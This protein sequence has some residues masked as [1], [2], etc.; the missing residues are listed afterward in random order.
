MNIQEIAP[1]AVGKKDEIEK[2]KDF[3]PRAADPFS[4]ADLPPAL[5]EFHSPTTALVNMP[6]TPAAQYIS[7]LIGALTA[8]SIV[9][10]AVFPLN[11]VVSTTGK[12]IS[13]QQPLV[14]QPFETSIIHSID[15]HEGD[16]VHKGQVLVRLD[17][18]VNDADIEDLRSQTQS[19]GAE[20]AR[21][22]AEAQG[23]DYK[24]DRDNPASTQ[25]AE[26]FLRR[27]AEF[28]AKIANYQ[29]QIASQTADLQGDL[30]N[31]DMY[32]A[33]VKVAN[34][35]RAMRARLQADQVGSRLSTLSAQNDLMEVTRSEI[36]AQHDG[37]SVRS[38][39][40]ALVAERQ[41]YIETWKA[42]IYHDLSD[43]QH[44]LSTADSDY[45]KAKLRKSMTVLKAQNDAIVLT[46][47]KLST[48]SVLTTGSEL[49]TLVPIDSG[50]EVETHLSGKDAGFVQPGNK[51]LLKFATF[52]YSQ[53][54]GAEATV[55]EISAD[56]F[57]GQTGQGPSS[58]AERAA[59][60]SNDP[61]DA[62]QSY[63]RVRLRIERYTLHG[64]PSFFH[65]RPGMPV[66]ADIQ[67]G[68]RTIMRFLLNSIMPLITDGMREP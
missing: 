12:I 8:S 48:G 60:Q 49:M 61:A 55:R 45:Q 2:T 31:A 5:I 1:P 44:K 54:G 52:P 57:D 35:V 32:A 63:Y 41:G 9:F 13:T 4:F 20:V 38:K 26:T 59:A 25:Q 6:P 68:K 51:A 40:Q 11:R 27:K 19:Y 56:T 15:V 47:A 10:M 24:P 64:V 46:I 29:E 50:L 30:A 36:L 65:P 43:A 37:A 3:L 66:T 17:P 21:L 22:S 34:D 33:R 28:D 62:A 53:Y 39:L 67:V 14:V 58:S 18:T 42:D 7:W 23:R 16:L